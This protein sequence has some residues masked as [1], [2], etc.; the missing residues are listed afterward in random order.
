MPFHY[1]IGVPGVHVLRNRA[2]IMSHDRFRASTWGKGKPIMYSIS[3]HYG[4]NKI[5][6]DLRLEPSLLLSKEITP[7]KVS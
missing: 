2:T 5:N 7:W 1:I 4:E 3:V 6:N